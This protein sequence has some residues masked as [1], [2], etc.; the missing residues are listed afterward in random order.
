MKSGLRTVLLLIAAMLTATFLPPTQ[1]PAAESSS[2]QAQIGRANEL[3]KQGKHEEALRVVDEALGQ[4]EVQGNPAAVVPVLML[5]MGLQTVQRDFPGAEASAKRAFE[6]TDKVRA[7]PLP[8][9]AFIALNTTMLYLTW[10]RPA[11]A[12]PWAQRAVA[13]ME[14]FDRNGSLHRSALGSLA[15]VE[16]AIGKYA[17]AQQHIEQ[18]VA[19]EEKLP[20]RNPAGL[21]TDLVRLGDLRGKRGDAPGAQAAYARALEF[22]LAQSN[23]EGTASAFATLARIHRALGRDVDAQAALERAY[24]AAGAASDV[25][26][27]AFSTAPEEL[28]KRRLASDKLFAWRQIGR[29]ERDRGRFAE[30]E[31][32]FRRALA[33]SEL[34]DGPGNLN[35]PSI[36]VELGDLLRA[37]AAWTAAEEAYLSAL[38]TLD[39]TAG[40]TA[41]GMPAALE[42]LARVRW[43][44]G[45]RAEAEAA[46]RREIGLYEAYIA[47]DHP[48]LAPALELLAE[49][50][51][52]SGRDSD[53][54]PALARAA[55]IREMKR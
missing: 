29:I 33:M 45:E 39:K 35:Q 21:V 28:A 53:A 51:A 47:S 38:A 20:K 42:G 54:K 49:I 17:A 2:L 30:A 26:P 4:A 48:Q 55:A 52:A 7:S 37:R 8:T 46:V 24:A 27:L 5:R 1:A 10:G 25:S 31:A 16:E 12:E 41:D 18:E 9:G 34:I 11:L 14:K 19:L 43:A 50:L 3:M 36:Q 44:K 40:G 15:I 22:Q 32:G 23:T 13:G 6:L